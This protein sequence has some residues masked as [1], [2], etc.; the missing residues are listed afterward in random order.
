MNELLVSIYPRVRQLVHDDLSAHFRRRN[1][2]IMPLFSTGDVVQEVFLRV[3]RDLPHFHGDSETNLIGW[4]AT[5][6]RRRILDLMRHHRALRRD[7]VRTRP[8]GDDESPSDAA[9]ESGPTDS[10]IAGELSD[11]YAK[12][13]AT[14]TERERALLRCRI[15]E[16]LAWKQVAERLGFVSDEAAR[17]HFRKLQARLLAQLSNTAGGAREEGQ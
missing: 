1:P 13:V 16:D 15:V 5:L 17:F 14:L 9:L 2:W 7:Q 4:L 8:I 12:A 3:I 11:A 6:V 10:L